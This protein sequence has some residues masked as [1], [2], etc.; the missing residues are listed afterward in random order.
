[1]MIILPCLNQKDLIII[2][3]ILDEIRSAFD[4]LICSS[5]GVFFFFTR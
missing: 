1:M 5:I 3:T 4:L 2:C